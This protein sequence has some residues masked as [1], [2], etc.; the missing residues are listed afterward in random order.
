MLT[1]TM[2]N[3][4]DIASQFKTTICIRPNTTHAIFRQKSEN[5]KT[6]HESE[7]QQNLIKFVKMQKTNTN[8]SISVTASTD[9]SL[10][11]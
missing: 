10:S 8:T 7:S 9:R 6:I 1:L 11:S 2:T 4:D 3:D 5:K